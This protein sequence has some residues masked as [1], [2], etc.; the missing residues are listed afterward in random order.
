MEK[1]I[2]IGLVVAVDCGQTHFFL[3]LFLFYFNDEDTDAKDLEYPYLN[4]V[5]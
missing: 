5:G 3:F 2:I 1:G 4:L